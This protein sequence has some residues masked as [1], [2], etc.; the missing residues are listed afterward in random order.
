MD[1]TWRFGF[2]RSGA[3]VGLVPTVGVFHSNLRGAGC[4]CISHRRGDDPVRWEISRASLGF[5]GVWQVCAS[6]GFH[7][8]FHSNA[9]VYPVVRP[10]SRR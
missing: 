4:F 10:H 9:R 5:E 7:S 2:F 3:A 6:D 1:K 8:E